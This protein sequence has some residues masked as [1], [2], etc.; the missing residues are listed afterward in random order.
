LLETKRLGCCCCILIYSSSWSE[1]LRH[2][3]LVLAKLQ[4]HH[5]FVKRPKCSFGERSVAYLGHVISTEGVAMDEQKV[6][7]VLD[8]P[9][10]CSVHTVRAFLGLVGYYRCF[11]K[12]YGTI[13]TPL[14]TLLKKDAF[15]W[16]AEAKEAFQALQR[17]LTTTPIL[18]L[19]DFDHDFVVECDASGT[20]LGAVLHQ[21][22]GPVAFFSRQLAPQHTKLAAYEWELIGLVQAVRH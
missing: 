3:I 21:G 15:K 16:S 12:N 10:P 14:T 17:A 13:A 20:G 2:I 9:L 11:I 7:A 4:E 19:P 5:L 22:S 1:H 18:Q 8:W 6:R